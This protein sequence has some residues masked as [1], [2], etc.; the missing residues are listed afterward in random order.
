MH[1]QALAAVEVK[2]EPIPPVRD[3]GQTTHQQLRPHLAWKLRFL[4][5]WLKIE[6]AKLLQVSAKLAGRA[7]GDPV[8]CPQAIQDR[9]A[10]AALGIARER[11]ASPALE[12]LGRVMK[13]DKPV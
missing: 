5:Q 13:S 3:S 12:A 7:A 6:A 11:D 10:N 2:G 8:P 4:R 9:P 1:C